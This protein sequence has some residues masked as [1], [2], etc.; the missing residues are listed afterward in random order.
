MQDILQKKNIYRESKLVTMRYGKN[1]ARA[2]SLFPKKIRYAVYV[3]YAWL[4]RADQLVDTTCHTVSTRENFFDWRQGWQDATL[5]KH[6]DMPHQ[7]MYRLC[8]YYGVPLEYFISFLHSME[9]DFSI[10]QYE[11]YQQLESYMYGS[12]VVVGFTLLCF[13]GLHRKN[14]LPGAQSLAEAMQLANFLRDIDEDYEQLGRIYIPKEDRQ[15]FG[16]T[17]DYFEKKILDEKFI[18]LMQFEIQRCRKL[19]KKAWVGIEQLPWR[20]KF[21][22][23][24]ATRNY[25]GILLEI[26]KSGYNIW[27]KKHA[28]SRFQ[29]IKVIIISL[30]V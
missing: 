23:R 5:Y 25:Q 6:T 16:V 30:F 21:P 19:Y 14:L 1:Y 2:V 22:I 13:F 26:E 20:V 15:M 18:A 3:Y 9:Q 12:A 7:E 29:K 11:T 27:D 28:L 8:M 10:K 24:V 4:R 17:N